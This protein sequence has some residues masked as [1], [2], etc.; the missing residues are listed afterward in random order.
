MLK[1][2]RSGEKLAGQIV[3]NGQVLR[4]LGNSEGE[5]VWFGIEADVKTLQQRLGSEFF[6]FD[7][8]VKLFEKMMSSSQTFP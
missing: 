7:R 2:E 3:W 1:A 5:R 6:I 4:E 8:F